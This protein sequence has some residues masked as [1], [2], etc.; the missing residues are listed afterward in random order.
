[1]SLEEIRLRFK[2]YDIKAYNF[3]Q[4]AGQAYPVTLGI[5]AASPHAG[6]GLLRS[7]PQTGHVSTVMDG[8][9]YS[10]NGIPVPSG[11][12]ASGS[13]GFYAAP[14][15]A[16]AGQSNMGTH[17]P[18]DNS[19]SGAVVFSAAPL[20]AAAGQSSMGN[21]APTEASASGAATTE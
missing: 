12:S 14:F 5:A 10:S 9:E 18:S 7:Q 2:I 4:Q 13:A 20:V 6:S 11:N 15:A 16:A 1:L 8:L 21:P 19:A 17:V 3:Q